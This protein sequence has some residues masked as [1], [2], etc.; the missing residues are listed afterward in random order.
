MT[1]DIGTRLP[2]PRLST[3]KQLLESVSGAMTHTGSRCCWQSMV[4][5]TVEANQLEHLTQA[6]VNSYKASTRNSEYFF[7]EICPREVKQHT[8]TAGQ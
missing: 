8:V 7:P 3:H 1:T 2:G 4:E 5:V 6:V